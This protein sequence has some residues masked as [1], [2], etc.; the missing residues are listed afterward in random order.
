M[1]GR[2]G[3]HSVNKLN[4][5]FEFGVCM[6]VCVWSEADVH[7]ILLLYYLITLDFHFEVP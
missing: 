4:H 3:V 6:C 7:H 2:Q 5:S 1:K